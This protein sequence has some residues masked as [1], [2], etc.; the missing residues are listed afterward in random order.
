VQ[1]FFA[2]VVGVPL[3][4]APN[5]HLGATLVPPLWAIQTIQMVAMATGI[6]G[7][8]MVAWNGAKRANKERGAILREFVPWALIL[9]LIGALAI[10]VFLQP[11][12]MRGNVLG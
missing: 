7:A 1:T 6:G 12:E 3:L 4:G 9:L 2:D 5:L 8:L 10:F 11:M